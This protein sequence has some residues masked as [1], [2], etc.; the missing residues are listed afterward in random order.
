MEKKYLLLSLEDERI[1]AVSEVL[2]NKT[3]SKIIDFLSE[4]KERSEKDIADE[5][6]LPINT[7]E[8]NLKKMLKAE[9]IEESKKFFWSPK[10]RRIKIY[11]LSNKS[12]IISPKSKTT[13]I[14]NEIKQILPMAL[15]SGI[16]AMVVK[17]YLDEK[18]AGVIAQEKTM[19]F[20]SEAANT[21][22]NAANQ[23]VNIINTG[24][25]WIWFLLGA[26]FITVLFIIKMV[27]FERSW[28]TQ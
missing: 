5:L 24:A 28:R 26:V 7:V 16:G 25:Y 9:L 18:T 3:S 8:Y 23:S 1:K 20:A 11:K 22:G 13:K 4:K 27:L 12:I 6:K 10:G 19:L 17:F 14:R 2:G 21:V 15:I